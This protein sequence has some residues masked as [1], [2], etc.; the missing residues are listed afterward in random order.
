VKAGEALYAEN[1]CAECHGGEQ[2]GGGGGPSFLLPGL[3]EQR[4]L[5]ELAQ[6]IRAGSPPAMPGYGGTLAEDQVWS[7]AA[8][9]RSLAWSSVGGGAPSDPAAVQSGSIAGLVINGTA[10]ASLPQGLEVILTGFDGEQEVYRQTAAVGRDGAYA[11][12]EVPVVEGRIY[13]ATVSHAGVLY[14]SEGAHLAGDGAPLDLPITIHDTTTDAAAL[15]IERLHLLFDFSIA[16]RIQVLELWV[17]SNPSDRTIVAAPG[18]GSVEVALPEGASDLGFEEGS[19]GDR[20]TLTESGFG[21]TQ[22]VIPG[23]ATSQ[24][25]FSYTLPYDGRLDFRRPT[26]YAVQAVVVLLPAEGVTADGSG[27]QDQGVQAMGGQSVHSYTS[28]A[29]A[30]GG[31]LELKLSGKPKA[32]AGG[33]PSGGLTNVAIGLGVLGSLM[34]VAGL[35]WFR[36][37]R[38]RRPQAASERDRLIEEI[39]ALDDAFA[40]GGLEESIYR[41]RRASLKR[42]LRDRM[43]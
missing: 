16:D 9:V 31:A 43:S 33:A 5:E 18:G 37:A 19:I 1:T 27:L 26:D 32:E 4:S 14:F 10:G 36:P 3:V 29:I 2:G 38:A 24:F 39:A 21:D 41:A 25:I 8:Y 17:L 7:L 40:A 28:G 23:T 6:A 35:W 15:S 34:I 13:G 30:A 20:F 11:F 12:A 42:S 22:P